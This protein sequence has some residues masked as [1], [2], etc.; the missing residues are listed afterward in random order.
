MPFTHELKVW[1][2]YFNDIKSGKKKFEVR[3]DDRNFKVGDTLTLMEFSAIS[4]YSGRSI[5]RKII[6]KLPG[7]EFGIHSGYCVLGLS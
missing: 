4:G 1:P 6:Y 5:Q 3:R 2:K 7:G